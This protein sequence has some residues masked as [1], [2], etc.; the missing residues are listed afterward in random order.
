MKDEYSKVDSLAFDLE[1]MCIEMGSMQ[2][3]DIEKLYGAFVFPDLRIMCDTYAHCW[4]ILKR[5]SGTEDWIEV[6]R[7][8]VD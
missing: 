4:R 7:V 5:E 1:D 3:I 2:Y 8:E 6:S